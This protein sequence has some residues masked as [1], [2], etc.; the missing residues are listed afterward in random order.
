MVEESVGSSVRTMCESGMAME[1]TYVCLE[2]ALTTCPSHAS[3]R[4][5]RSGALVTYLEA[6]L[7]SFERWEAM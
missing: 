7:E 6:C 4:G 3:S 1:R 5:G 2:T